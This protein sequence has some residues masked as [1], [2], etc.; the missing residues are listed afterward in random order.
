MA[1]EY[2]EGDE[3]RGHQ[4]ICVAHKMKG[5]E[6]DQYTGAHRGQWVR[7]TGH[8]R[9]WVDLPLKTY[10]DTRPTGK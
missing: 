9:A 5:P 3:I 10:R 7:A 8:A 4:I 1:R 6:L 2:G